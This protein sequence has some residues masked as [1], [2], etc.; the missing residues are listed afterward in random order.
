MLH[1]INISILYVFEEGITTTEKYPATLGMLTWEL[2]NLYLLFVQYN[3]NS[4]L[5]MD[6]S[7]PINLAFAF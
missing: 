3:G 6:R 7:S 4:L 5:P 2:I 1:I